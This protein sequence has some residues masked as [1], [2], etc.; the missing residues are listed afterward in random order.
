MAVAAAGGAPRPARLRHRRNVRTLTPGQL[1]SYRK[2]IAASQKLKDDR[3]YQAMA[4]IHGL[5]LPISCT[6]NSE[7]FLP[8]HRAYLFFF[9]KSLQDRVPGVTLPWW[10]WTMRHG[11]GIPP[12]FKA[13]KEADGTPNPLRAANGGARRR[14]P[15]R[16]ALQGRRRCRRCPRSTGC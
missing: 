4:G 15:A 8:W 2:A 6:H 14:R 13:A 3:G 10:N 11:E 1:A 7:L 12:A 9:E 16:R 5:P